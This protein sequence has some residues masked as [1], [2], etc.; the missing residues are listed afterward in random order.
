M[1]VSNRL[2]AAI[3]QLSNLLFCYN[4]VLETLGNKQLYEII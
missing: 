4:K 1:Y 3:N 2:L